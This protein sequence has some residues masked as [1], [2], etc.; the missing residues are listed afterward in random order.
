M[1]EE[2]KEKENREEKLQKKGGEK[3]FIMTDKKVREY[4]KSK[5]RVKRSKGL[6][7]KVHQGIYF[8]LTPL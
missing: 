6:I 1:Q 7:L 3:S 8:L 5:K 2:E 4:E